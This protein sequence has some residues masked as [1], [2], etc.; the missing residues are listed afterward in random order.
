MINGHIHLSKTSAP[1]K[2]SR[3]NSFH[4][5][6]NN[7][8]GTVHEVDFELNGTMR[9][10]MFLNGVEATLRGARYVLAQSD[11]TRCATFVIAE[12]IDLND[13]LC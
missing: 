5:I 8:H 11:K 13:K 3:V 10:M 2:S 7:N 9:R 1:I 6:Q 12:D 4:V